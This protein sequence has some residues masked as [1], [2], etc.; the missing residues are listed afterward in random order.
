LKMVC[1]AEVVEK[2]LRRAVDSHENLRKALH[3]LR[4]EMES[5]DAKKKLAK[6]IATEIQ[7][8][9]GVLVCFLLPAG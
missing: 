8:V 9:G 7:V 4:R 6:H 3:S 1:E 5:F 2:A